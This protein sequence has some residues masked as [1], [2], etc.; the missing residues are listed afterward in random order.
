VAQLQDDDPAD[1]EE[2]PGSVAAGPDAHT[3]EQH[4]R[5]DRDQRQPDQRPRPVAPFAQRLGGDRVLLALVRDHQRGRD[6][7]QD[8]RAADQRQDDEADPVE[9]GMDVEI[10]RQAP[11][12]PGEHAVRPAP[13]EALRRRLLD[14][15]LVHVARIARPGA[16]GHPD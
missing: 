14:C 7:D 10:A 1:Q 4:E 11:A 5:G 8:T 2:D 9:R 15:R 12:H 6:V 3:G 16:D 13:L